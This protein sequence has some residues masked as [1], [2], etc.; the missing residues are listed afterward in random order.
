[1]SEIHLEAVND[2]GCSCSKSVRGPWP[3]TMFNRRRMYELKLH[4]FDHPLAKYGIVVRSTAETTLINYSYS[5][6]HT[7]QSLCSIDL[8][9]LSCFLCSACVGVESLQHLS[10][11]FHIFPL[12]V[13]YPF[14]S[15]SKRNS[16]DPTTER[17]GETEV[18][19]PKE[20]GGCNQNGGRSV[21]KII[22]LGISRSFSLS[23]FGGT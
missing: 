18:D 4:T 3:S 1:M 21:G 9:Y 19:R 10:D 23:L 11:V 13:S 6:Y 5:Y 16:S 20:E 2:P 12:C 15:A 22:H 14:L 7:A 8:S 17:L